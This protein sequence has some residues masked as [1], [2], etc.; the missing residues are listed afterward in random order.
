MNN[1]RLSNFDLMKIIS[2][3]FIILYH[4][5]MHGNVLNNTTG[6]LNIT[7]TFIML[8][9]LVHVNS[10]VLVTG[11]F[12]YNKEF[13]LSKLISLNN[14]M[15]FYKVVILI[16]FTFLGITTLSK[17]ETFKILMPINYNDYWFIAIYSFLYL[18]SPLLNI[19]IKNIN[20]YQHKLT[21]II[22]FLI[23]CVL[24]TLTY[25]VAYN[26]NVGY[27]LS[28][29]IM[30]YFIG[31]Y[32]SKYNIKILKKIDKKTIRI[33]CILI[34][35]L[36]SSLNTFIF[37]SINSIQNRGEILNY[38]YDII[39][40]AKYSY[41]NPLVVIQ[42]I[43]YFYF[44]K[45]LNIKNKLITNISS[46]TFGIYLIHDNNL[47]RLYLYKNI[48]KL[49]FI[50]IYSSSII[51]KMLLYTIL[52]FITCSIIEL[53]RKIIFKFFYNRKISYKIRKKVI[54]YFNKKGIT[55]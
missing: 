31:A 54:R 19:V 42:S 17:I 47:I 43:S 40:S 49:P 3:L 37:A 34:M 44:F 52:I 53:V 8:T 2:M 16:I 28:N 36:S 30:L 41:C 33:I 21:I 29:F 20:K 46:L 23:L 51:P 9:L 35:L 14:S 25:Q 13:K 5:L 55:W 4:I 15:W 18:I 39:S 48:L 45:T 22:M 12:Q 27:S 10:F 26:N 6:K 24:S 50:T 38:I 32:I 11:Y 1:K 7:L